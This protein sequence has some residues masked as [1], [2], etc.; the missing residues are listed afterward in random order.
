MYRHV[1]IPV[2]CSEDARRAVPALAKYLSEM[3]SCR[4]TLV[5]AISPTPFAELHDKKVAHAREALRS[6]SALLREYGVY[7]NGRIIE[8]EEVSVAVEEES[9][10]TSEMYD[11]ILLST[12]QTRPEDEENPCAGSLADRLSRR[13][14]IPVLVLPT[15]VPFANRK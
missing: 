6:V 9:R 2:D 14:D 1:L 12:Y 13:V 3:M 11:L 8:G 10:L 15:R 4:A 7:T 5:A